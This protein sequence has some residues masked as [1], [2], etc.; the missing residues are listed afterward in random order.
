MRRIPYQLL[1]A[2]TALLMLAPQVFATDWSTILPPDSGQTGQA[3]VDL[4]ERKLVVGELLTLPLPGNRSYTCPVEV[5]GDAIRVVSHDSHES[6]TLQG[7]TP[8]NSTVRIYRKFWSDPDIPE[9]RKPVQEI[10]LTV[11]SAFR[12]NHLI[13][14]NEA[15]DSIPPPRLRSALDWEGYLS[16]QSTELVTVITDGKEWT[17]LWDRAFGLPAPGVD[18][19]KHAVACV[20]LGFHADW[21][22]GIHVEEPRAEG[23]VQVIPYFLSEI[24]LRLQGPFRGSGQY[25]MKAFEKQQG[26]GMVLKRIQF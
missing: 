12:N 25:R 2:L 24:M 8:G 14:R 22:Y 19:S 10:A 23:G 16:R 15:P 26:Y 11:V 7:V 4:L 5:D 9:S 18:F 21:L 3:K 17:E 20:F 13:D 1:A 6:V